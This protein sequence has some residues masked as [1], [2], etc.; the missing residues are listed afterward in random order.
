MPKTFGLLNIIDN[1]SM[2]RNIK[3][4]THFKIVCHTETSFVR[5][6]SSRYYIKVIKVR[7]QKKLSLTNYNCYTDC[8]EYS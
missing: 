3:H 1:K 5:V 4:C 6:V 8:A 7:M 2:P